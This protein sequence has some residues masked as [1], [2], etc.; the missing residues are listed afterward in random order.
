MDYP[1][2]GTGVWIRKDGKVLLGQRTGNYYPGTWCV[3]GGKLEMYE[4]WEDCARR[5]TREEAGVEIKNLRLIAITNG[6][7]L[8]LGVHYVTLQFAADLVSG[9]AIVCEPDKF[10]RW[11]WFPYDALPEPLFPATGNFVEK[12]YNPFV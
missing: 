6:Y 11:E 9:E 3:P 10:A 8:E 5:E 4:E 1:G 2:V 12:G 7:S